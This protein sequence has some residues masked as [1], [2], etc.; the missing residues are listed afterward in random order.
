MLGGIFSRRNL[1]KQSYDKL[2]DENL[3]PPKKTGGITPE[4]NAS[5]FS[6]FTFSWF[7]PIID[8]ACDHIL[9]L[10]EYYYLPQQNNPSY[11]L[12]NFEDK[13]R[14]E[15][16]KFEASKVF[17]GKNG[18]NTSTNSFTGSKRLKFPSLARVLF[19]CYSKQVFIIFALVI[20]S[21][22]CNLTQIFLLR[23]L[24]ECIQSSET[25]PR[26]ETFTETI[27]P[28]WA[29][30]LGIVPERFSLSIAFKGFAYIFAMTILIIAY[31]LLRQQETRIVT[32][33]GRQIRS[34]ITGV[35]YR[36]LLN[37]DSNIFSESPQSNTELTSRASKA[38]LSVIS[39]MSLEGATESFGMSGNVVNL[40]NNDV[41][42]FGRLYT[43]HE[44][45]Y[46]VCSVTVA[47]IMLYINIGI[48]GV[49]G[50]LVMFAHSAWS[51][52]FLNARAYVRKS[53]SE[54]RDRRIL[55][56][57]EY[58]KYIKI[59]KSY[60]WERYFIKN[61]DSHRENE[62]S[63]LLTQG[64]CWGL[65]A[66][67]HAV[68]FHALLFT[69]LARK[70]LGEVIDP[71]SVFFAYVV[72]DAVSEFIAS[73][74]KSY[75]LFR[76]LILSCERISEF[77]V[78][79][80][81]SNTNQL[82]SSSACSS[83]SR[84]MP[85]ENQHA[86]EPKQGSV[87]Y[88]GVELSW[89]GGTLLLKELSFEV[90]PGEMMAILGPVGSGKSGLLLSI[91]NELQHSKGLRKVS[92][93]L[94]YVPQ[95]AWAITGTIREN[96]LF[97]APFEPE[98]YIQVVDACCLVADFKIFPKGDQTMI[99][100]TS[101]NLSGGQRQRI[102][103]A[104]AV[105]QKSHI[106]ALDDCLS[107]VD[108]NVSA[109]I[110][111]NCILGLLRDKC[112]IL[113]T[114][115]ADFAIHV[116]KVLLL[117]D[118]SKKPLYMGEPYGL[119]KFPHYKNLFG[120]NPSLSKD[121]EKVARL[122]LNS[123]S[124]ESLADTSTV[125][126]GSTQSC[127]QENI[128]ITEEED[129]ISRFKE[130]EGE[131]EEE[132]EGIV[133]LETYMKYIFS[134]KKSILFALFIYVSL[135]VAIYVLITFFIGIWV[136][137]ANEEN[138][139]TYFYTYLAAC[140]VLPIVCTLTTIF[141]RLGGIGVSKIYH[142]KLL[143]HIEHAPLSFFENTPIGRVLN[144]FTSDLVH[145]DELL[146]TSFN[147][148]SVTVLM[149]ATMLV[150]VGIVTPQFIAFIPPIFYAFYCVAKKYPPIL[151]QSER[152]SAALTAP[153]TSQ[154]METM[155][156]LATI[157]TFGAENMLI[158]KMDDAIIALNNIRYHLDIAYIWLYLRLEVIGCM[159][160]VVTGIFSVLL[161]AC[162]LSN[163][164][165]LGTILSFAVALPGWLRYSIFTLGEFE[166]DMVGFERIR[167]YTDSEMYQIVTKDEE[168][169]NIEVPEDWPSQGKIE[170]RNV[171]ITFYPNPNP[172]LRNIS[173]KISPGERIGIV[174]RTGAGK[175]SLFSAILRL[176]DP[177]FGAILIDD[178]ETSK[179][180]PLRLR[181]SISIVP[182]D[183]VIFTGTVR[184]NLDPKGSCSDEEL[185]QVLKRAH[186]F[187]YVNS[188]PGKLNFQLE[189]GGSQLSVGI[190]QLFCLTRA[191]LRKSRILLLDE[192]TSFVDIQTDSLIQE[193]IK[194]EFK[195]CT[196][197]TI[198][199]RIKTIINYDRILVLE[200][201]RVFEFDTPQNLL[202]NPKSVF[203]SLA[204]SISM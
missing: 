160:L 199:H 124:R 141:F 196:I 161:S 153:I 63:S 20:F 71:A 110:F 102:S 167:T 130:E 58:L 175:S 191:I 179:V 177:S 53:F 189:G 6:R 192:A 142:D 172:S 5:F 188:L 126:S 27:I 85:V 79:E 169:S 65:A 56:T 198:A 98:W 38:R 30:V 201:G 68:V 89:P 60:S 187:E 15:C 116:D 40:L 103:L 178:V 34:L 122:S 1:K 113:A 125:R 154:L 129:E 95:L 55:L 105:Y 111:R 74:P 29:V 186:I 165:I 10:D 54:I 73:F 163:P 87:K 77:L 204:S 134:Y 108:S 48:S 119:F 4:E 180:L 42:R 133:S 166:A 121:D 14:A 151:R 157:H 49:I 76:D 162:N 176:F 97:G 62:I 104:R 47:T 67:C 144:R 146:P 115:L 194:S 203:S 33:L 171:D 8:S 16:E 78:I 101:N 80:D 152:K 195:G 26:V 184:F 12:P 19:Q 145:L 185:Y 35:V 190:K 41:S 57:S 52:N 117:D 140:I 81:R 61:I 93:K 128:S 94:A 118:I 183:P 22:I 9:S 202:R 50:I 200:S 21:N 168:K 36:K 86:S 136:E 182:Q 135:L 137:N 139:K 158:K 43:S 193:T 174:G 45:Y 106:Y 91:I 18:K 17:E 70:Y 143:S 46:G 31:T 150:S 2:Q 82:L 149:S 75:A 155:S 100:G 107:A 11:S 24:L 127:I 69:I 92:G 23:K 156:G 147:N 88:E 131:N 197:L 170:F 39:E 44:F 148:S 28:W 66:A 173:L 13:W 96:I 3:F 59:I 159:T 132:E 120:V 37:L 138:W 32:R 51:I 72:Y 64:V 25:I 181:D 84:A 123:S 164:G 109:R 99:S 83:V 90:R 112:V 7:T 114:H